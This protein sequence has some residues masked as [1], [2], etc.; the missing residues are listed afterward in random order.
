MNTKDFDDEKWFEALTGR[1]SEKDDL[2]KPEL[3]GKILRDVILN[4]HRKTLDT[5]EN[6]KQESLERLRFKIKREGLSKKSLK[7]PTTRKFWGIPLPTAV[8]AAISAA[9]LLPFAFQSSQT[10][11]DTNLDESLAQSPLMFESQAPK[12]SL[13]SV[14][15]VHSETPQQTTTK[16]SQA[17]Q[18]LGISN[19]AY[20]LNGNWHLEAQVDPNKNADTELLA[21]SQEYGFNINE[22]G[23][24]NI[25]IKAK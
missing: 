4:E 16:L 17:L 13:G 20:Q 12:A 14:S 25:L 21:L 5:V 1:L 7:T 6:P 8:A 22:D 18:R 23:S 2:S 19:Q 15:L 10:P 9:I 24:I 3:E 11:L